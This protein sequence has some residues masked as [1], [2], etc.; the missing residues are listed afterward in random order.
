[1]AVDEEILPVVT[2]TTTIGIDH[3][4]DTIPTAIAVLPTATATGPIMDEAG[5]T[6]TGVVKV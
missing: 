1:M 5:V 4:V 2:A 3:Q 6:I